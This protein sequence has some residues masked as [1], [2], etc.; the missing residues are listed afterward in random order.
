M[1]PI[2]VHL[3]NKYSKQVSPILLTNTHRAFLKKMDHNFTFQISR[4]FLPA[5]LCMYMA[6]SRGAAPG[7]NLGLPTCQNTYLPATQ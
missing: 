7:E 6:G 2:H 4:P 5:V 3:T 1:N